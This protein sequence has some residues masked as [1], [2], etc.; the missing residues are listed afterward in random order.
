MI[1]QWT[2]W[3][4]A[5]LQ[6]YCVGGGLVVNYSYTAPAAAETPQTEQRLRVRR[7]FTPQRRHNRSV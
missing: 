6:H 5:Q 7:V 3:N 4:K 2:Y 1:I